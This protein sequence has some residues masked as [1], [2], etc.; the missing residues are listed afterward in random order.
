MAQRMQD[1]REVWCLYVCIIPGRVS[2]WPEYFWPA[3]QRA[4]PTTA[5]RD[6]VLRK[7]GYRRPS[8]FASWDWQETEG[9]G[10]R[11]RVF[12]SIEVHPDT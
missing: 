3:S 5:Q 2:Q 1:R 4:I 7:L 8:D 11:V 12:A 6:R 9:T 10:G